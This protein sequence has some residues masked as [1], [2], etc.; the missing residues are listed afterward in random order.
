MI[1]HTPIARP[2]IAPSVSPSSIAFE[3]PTAWLHA[4]ILKPAVTG[5]FTL[6][7]RIKNGAAIFPKIPVKITATTVME[8]I[9]PC[10]EEMLT[11]IG[12]VTDLGIM[13]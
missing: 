10:A 11:A 1:P 7:R 3:V 6:N 12:V 8:E 9:P 2:L 4:P 13:E 5:S